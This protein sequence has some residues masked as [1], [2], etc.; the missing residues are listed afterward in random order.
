MFPNSSNIIAR[1]EIEPLLL[2]AQEAL[3]SYEKSTNVTVSVLDRTGH[4]IS[5]S[6]EGSFA[7]D[8]DKTH[9]SEYFCSLCRQYSR[10]TDRNW[11]EGEYPCTQI[12]I[13]SISQAYYSGGVYIYVCELGFT[14]WV[15]PL[16]SSGWQAGA[17]IAGLVLGIS[18][19]EVAEKISLMS[20][21]QINRTAADLL[22]E[23][24][25]EKTGEEIKAMARLLLICTEQISRGTETHHEILKR[26]AEQQSKLS[27]QIES[28]KNQ[29]DTGEV[30]PGYPLEKERQLL[31]SLHRGDNEKARKAL[32]EL[33]ALLFFSNPDNFKFM[34]YRAIELVVL[35]S[36]AAVTSG[37]TEDVLLE[38]N[39]RYLMR[40]QEA[41]T[42][43]EILD[44]LYLVVD[45]MTEQ[46][47]PFKGVR[48]ASSLRKAERYIWEN[49][50]RKVSLQ[51]VANASGLSAP[52]FSTVFK[53]EMG[54][55]LSSYLNRLR[56]DRAS[57]LLMETELSLSEIAGFCGFDDQSWFSKIFKSYTGM[58]PGKYRD[59]NR[60]S[61]KVLSTDNLSVNY[62]SM[63]G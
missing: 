48:H 49:Y 5:A 60:S 24:I 33:L 16:S 14:Y 20:R 27:E 41:Q 50:T 61:S 11:E 7:G 36:R 46:I 44:V 32:D 53:E 21:G 18:K 30:P 55:N 52:Y 37:N 25:P 57:G 13:D 26:R 40:I 23:G 45:N 6:S 58:S 17:L 35:I 28:L 9:P 31:S 4:Y 56:I 22:L 62:R 42:T 29:H 63:D 3:R 39:N 51:E 8:T 47:S 15:C 59:Q 12:H 54:E 1:R 38:I 43:E 19:Q 34:Q 2:K 10:E